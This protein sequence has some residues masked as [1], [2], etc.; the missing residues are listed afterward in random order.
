MH[1]T[2][3]FNCFERSQI[4][5]IMTFYI[6]IIVSIGY[7]FNLFFFLKKIIKFKNWSKCNRNYAQKLVEILSSNRMSHYSL[8]L[9]CL[10]HILITYVLYILFIYLQLR[11]YL[12]KN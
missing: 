7:K 5:N 12:N 10:V 4:E 9:I 6:S 2:L 3:E 11:L 8:E 1:A